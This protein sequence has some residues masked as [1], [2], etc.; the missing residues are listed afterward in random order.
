[1]KWR[2]LLACLLVLPAASAGTSEHPDLTDAADDVGVEPRPDT[3]VP[4]AWYP[5]I[6]LEKVWFTDD[7]QGLHATIQVADLSTVERTQAG[8][9]D[10]M[11]VAIWQAAYANKG[12]VAGRLGTWELRAEY[13]PLD[14]VYGGGPA[15][16]FWLER[17]CT[18]GNSDDGCAGEARDI[19]DGLQGRLDYANSTITMTAPWWDLGEVQPGDG[20]FGLAATA[21]SM[22]PSYPI[23]A[24][25]WDWDEF[26]CY[27]FTSVP[28]DPAA[29][30]GN[31]TGATGTSAGRWGTPTARPT[32]DTCVHAQAVPANVT[33]GPPASGTESQGAPADVG[34]EQD[35][36]TSK[37]APMPIPFLALGLAA[38]A[39]RSRR[40]RSAS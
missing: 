33:S 10:T 29:F 30:R 40:P 8:D 23:A 1:M 5:A 16:H 32:K 18:D 24:A 14:P 36:G 13:R 9:A 20:I 19:L 3:A 31:D 37:A 25:D 22:W 15:W 35:Y 2:L 12:A 27:M 17:P 39:A 38:L 6:D 4:A 21:E 11:Y 7:A 34:P 28:T 26:G